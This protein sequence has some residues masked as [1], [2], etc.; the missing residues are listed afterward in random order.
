MNKKEC[1]FRNIN[2]VSYYKCAQ[3][4]ISQMYI[5]NKIGFGQVQLTI[6][7]NDSLL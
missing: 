6:K 2:K 3:P 1:V 4:Y 5:K 7:M